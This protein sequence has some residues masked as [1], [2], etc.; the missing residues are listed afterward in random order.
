[1]R[2]LLILEVHYSYYS[3]YSYMLVCIRAYARARG[4]V[5]EIEP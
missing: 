5:L 1:M 4:R 3:Y 2:K